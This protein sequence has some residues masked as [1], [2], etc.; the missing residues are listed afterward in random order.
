MTRKKPADII[1]SK[2][3]AIVD[4]LHP[5]YSPGMMSAGFLRGI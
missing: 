4:L 1:T 3:S 5:S 2:E